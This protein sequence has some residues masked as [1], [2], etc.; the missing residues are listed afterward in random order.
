MV[1]WS[2]ASRFVGVYGRAAAH[3]WLQRFR[4]P[5]GD[6]VALTDDLVIHANQELLHRLISDSTRLIHPPPIIIVWTYGV[7]RLSWPLRH[8]GWAKPDSVLT[9]PFGTPL[10]HICITYRFPLR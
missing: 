1:P 7:M 10:T 2:S 4:L 3:T 6:V 5:L 8:L 9:T